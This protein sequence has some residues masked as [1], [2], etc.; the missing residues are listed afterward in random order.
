VALHWLRHKPALV[1]MNGSNAAGS[2]LDSVVFQLVAFGSIDAG[3]CMT[4]AASKMLGGFVW[5]LALYKMV[6][7]KK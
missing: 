5:S 3:L 6:G 7:G 1:R 2:I 4:Q